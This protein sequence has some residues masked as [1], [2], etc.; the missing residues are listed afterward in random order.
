MAYKALGVNAAG[1]FARLQDLLAGGLGFSQDRLQPL[2]KIVA[3][4]ALPKNPAA[5][6]AM[7]NDIVHGTRGVDAGS[8]KNG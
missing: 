1:L 2:E 8:A 6:N 3:V 5:L 4:E 7:A